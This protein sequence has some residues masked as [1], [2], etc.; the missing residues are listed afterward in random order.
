MAVVANPSYETPGADYG[1]AESWIET[2]TNCGEQVAT[3]FYHEGPRRPS[4]SFESSWD[5]NHLYETAFALA[6]LVHALLCGLAVPYEN[7][8]GN[9]HSPQLAGADNAASVF[10]FVTANHVAALFADGADEENF[11]NGW[12]ISPFNEGYDPNGFDAAPD[13]RL[14]AAAFDPLSLEN[15][16]DFEEYWQSNQ[17]YDTDG[18][19]MNGAEPNLTAAVFLS[20]FTYDGFEAGWTT[21]LP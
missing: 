9:W 2:Y 21:T 1:E 19:A 8:E 17:T 7:F 15:V 3:F 12:G 20:G 4:E 13:P 10:V 18:F 6:D 16:E 14:T 11:E 5:D